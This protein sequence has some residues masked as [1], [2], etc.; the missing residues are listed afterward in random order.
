LSIEKSGAVPYR[1]LV[2]ILRLSSMQYITKLAM[3]QS[4]K[5]W[6]LVPATPNYKIRYPLDANVRGQLK[7]LLYTK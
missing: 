1:D 3:L 5:P 4:Q 2:T 6:T 7:F